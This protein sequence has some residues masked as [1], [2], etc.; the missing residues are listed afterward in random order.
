VDGKVKLLEGPGWGIE[1]RP[2]WLEKAAYR[3][4]VVGG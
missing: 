2:G 1:M 4:S 3:K